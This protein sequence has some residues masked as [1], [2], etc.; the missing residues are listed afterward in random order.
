[1]PKFDQKVLVALSIFYMLEDFPSL[2]FSSAD[3]RILYR[4]DVLIY[5]YCVLNFSMII[6]LSL[7]TAFL[8]LE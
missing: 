6:L 7:R 1:M 2:N 5:L 8:N 4:K 3:S